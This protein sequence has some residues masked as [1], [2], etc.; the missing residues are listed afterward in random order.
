MVP[1]LIWAPDFFGPQ[2]IWFARNLVSEKI[3]PK[4]IWYLH[5]NVIQ[6]FLCG[7]QI[8]QGPNQIKDHF[9]YSQN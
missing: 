8:S 7:D 1:D 9:I 5:E 4:E 6:Y 3:W 2:E